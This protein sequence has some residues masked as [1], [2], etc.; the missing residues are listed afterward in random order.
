MISF[1]LREANLRVTTDGT[2]AEVLV[3]LSVVA[4]LDVHS[5]DDVLQYSARD[6]C[7]EVAASLRGRMALLRAA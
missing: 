1:K 2:V 5:L 7:A 4:G 3:A 6:W